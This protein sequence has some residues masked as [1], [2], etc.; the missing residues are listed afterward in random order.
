VHESFLRGRGWTDAHSLTSGQSQLR[1]PCAFTLKGTSTK[2]EDAGV[3]GN[4]D[5]WEG[6][7][8]G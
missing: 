3:V 4:C 8:L 6:V 1:S 5:L 2:K 7:P